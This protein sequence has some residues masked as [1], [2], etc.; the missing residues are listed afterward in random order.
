[1]PAPYSHRR[2]WTVMCQ[3]KTVDRNREIFSA[4]EEGIAAEVLGAQ[5]N[6][7]VGR[8]RAILIEE[9]H[10]RNLSPEFFYQILRNAG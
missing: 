6:L 2:G 9:R 8:I 4:F 5:H 3:R 7:T 1:M 10:R